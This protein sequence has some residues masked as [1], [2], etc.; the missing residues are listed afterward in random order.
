MPLAIGESVGPYRIQVPLGAGG[1]GEVYRATD[2]RLKRDVA[3]KVLRTRLAAEPERLARFQREAELLA[4]LKHPNIAAIYG[5]EKADGVTAIVLELVEGET[6]DARLKP[7]ASSGDGSVGGKDPERE[8]FSRASALPLDEALPIAR[9]I[10]EALEAAHE[11]SVIHRDLKP[12]NIKVTPD[13]RVKVLDFGLAKMLEAEGAGGAGTEGAVGRN[14]AQ[15]FSPA[16]LTNSPT[17]SLQATVGGVILGTAAYMSPEQASG[18]PADKRSD[19]WSFGVVL[20]EML[21]GKSLF[22]GE[23]ISH[24]LAFVITREPDWNA[25]PVGTPSSIRRL[26]RRCLEKDRKRRLADIASARLEI[27]DALADVP[28]DTSATNVVPVGSSRQSLRALPWAL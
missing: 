17:L 9:Q 13:G 12:A 23:T 7:R 28:P 11:K 26:L 15:G 3:I 22:E 4:T 6:L 8:G 16:Y 27:D 21:T 19:V 18:K 20:W 14:V 1:M 24:T 10:A 2:T 5:L 25:L